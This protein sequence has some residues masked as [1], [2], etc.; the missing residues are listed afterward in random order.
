MWG[1]LHPAVSA[2]EIVGVL[3][4]PVPVL[5]YA[6]KFACLQIIISVYMGI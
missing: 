1:K 5:V 3:E 6:D 4:I 2:I